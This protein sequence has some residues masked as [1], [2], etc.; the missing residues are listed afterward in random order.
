MLQWLYTY[1]ARVCLQCFI[2]FSNVCCKHVNWDVAYVFTH[3]LKVFY[4][5]VT[6]VCNG[7]QVFLSV[8][9]SI[10]DAC[11]KCFICLFCMLQMLYLNISK[12]DQVLHMRYA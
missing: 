12:V 3:M 5:D 1:V 7:L 10:S 6:Y 9:A 11:F 2:F 8:F 4:L